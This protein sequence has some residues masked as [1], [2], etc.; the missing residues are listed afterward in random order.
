MLFPLRYNHFNFAIRGLGPGNEAA[1]D[2][3]Q[4]RPDSWIYRDRRLSIWQILAWARWVSSL[5]V[6]DSPGSTETLSVY[7]VWT[8]ET[9]SVAPSAGTDS[10]EGQSHRGTVIVK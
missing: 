9:L 6:G 7:E 5:T 8:S 10:T 4:S 1:H 2:R 3:H